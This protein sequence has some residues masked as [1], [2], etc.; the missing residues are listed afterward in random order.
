MLSMQNMFQGFSITH[1]EKSIMQETNV[2]KNE[3]YNLF[4]VHLF[5]TSSQL[6]RKINLIIKRNKS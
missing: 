4:D 5:I 6:S 3:M 2:I 1:A